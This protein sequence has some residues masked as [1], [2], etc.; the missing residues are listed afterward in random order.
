MCKD[1][2]DIPT[3]K[4]IMTINPDKE[5]TDLFVCFYQPGRCVQ[6]SRTGF[7]IN[8]FSI[9]QLFSKE[10]FDGAGAFA[11]LFI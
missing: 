9:V 3:K 6:S 7:L 11:D 5:T 4:R 8:P 1:F 2:D 10:E